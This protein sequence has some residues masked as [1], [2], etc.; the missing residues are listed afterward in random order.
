MQYFSRQD[1]QREPDGSEKRLIPEYPPTFRILRIHSA[2]AV[3]CEKYVG[4]AKNKED[5][6]ELWKLKGN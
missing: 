4:L 3:L 5:V 6:Q 2:S 1:R